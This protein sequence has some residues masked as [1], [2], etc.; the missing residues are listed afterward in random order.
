LDAPARIDDVACDE[1][2]I[3]RQLQ[4]LRRDGA[5]P[6]SV[7]RTITPSDKFHRL[8][9]TLAGHTRRLENFFARA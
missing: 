4:R 7:R 8:V 1:N 3:G 2:E 9:G 5:L 6:W